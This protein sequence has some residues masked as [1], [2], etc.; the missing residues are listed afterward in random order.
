MSR[1]TSRLAGTLSV[2]P[3]SFVL[4]KCELTAT[5][6][7]VI[8][9]KQLISEIT[10]TESIYMASIDADLMI[11]DAVNLLE[12]LKLNGDE[13]IELLIKRKELDSKDDE[14][15]K[16]T[17]YISEILDFSRTIPGTATY[18]MRCVSKHAYINNTLTLNESKQGTI[19][20]IIK[21][22]CISNLGIKKEGLDIQESTSKNIKCIIPKLRPIAAI[23][24]LNSN[25]YTSAGAPLYFFETLA[26]GIKYKSYEDFAAG[27]D[28]PTY[29]HTPVLDA[30]IGSPEYFAIASRRVR[31]ISSDFNLSKYISI[32]EGAFASTTSSIDISTKVYKPKS[33]EFK[34]D[35]E[36]LSTLNT[37]APY[38]VRANND[39]Y[40]GKEIN[41]IKTGKNYFISSNSMAYGSSSF[42]YH[43]PV[44]ENISVGQA[45]LS[46]ED[47]LTHDIVI[48]G[49]F[50]LECGG[51]LDLKV[52]KTNPSD[53]EA[54]LDKMQSGKYLIS[55][56]IHKFGNEYTQQLEIK[57]NSFA[58]EME[59]ILELD[60]KPK[61]G[62][63]VVST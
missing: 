12:E 44:E 41:N 19:G 63:E 34:Y 52:N 50:K 13:K 58:S 15:H 59:D 60:E 4:S 7:T 29:N 36:K 35:V 28:I 10:I 32:S 30:E 11:I 55:S 6:G 49:N 17:F 62:T 56:I 61:K 3:G 46:T 33:K 9:I 42:N 22:I 8:D 57:T 18:T 47:T 37:H 45:Y 38:P 39:Q 48:A 26:G 31:K 43:A 54:H 23:K 14:K 21:D 24:W 5:N 51:L 25:A 2:S 53:N 40:G 16:H 27:K 1:N 20:K